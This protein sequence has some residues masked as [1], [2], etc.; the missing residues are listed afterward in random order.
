MRF[1]GT[2]NTR[3]QKLAFKRTVDNGESLK[4]ITF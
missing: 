1:N 3:G 4:N 2:D